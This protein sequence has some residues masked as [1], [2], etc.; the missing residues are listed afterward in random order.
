[1]NPVGD[2]QLLPCPSSDVIADESQPETGGDHDIA[3]VISAIEPAVSP[4]LEFG[5]ACMSLW[6]SPSQLNPEWG[7][8]IASVERCPIR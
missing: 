3:L 4:R 8:L 1:M 5:A 6:W 2:S 7:C